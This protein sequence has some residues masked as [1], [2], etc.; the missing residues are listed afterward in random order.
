MATVTYYKPA[1]IQITIT[2]DGIDIIILMLR[3]E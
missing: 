3:D 1:R 2:E